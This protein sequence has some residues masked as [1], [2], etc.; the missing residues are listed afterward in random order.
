MNTAAL[1]NIPAFPPVAAKL[2]ELTANDESCVADLVHLLRSDPA[3][4]AQVIRH[5][6]SPLYCVAAQITGLD[7]AVALMGVRKIRTLALAVIGR[8]YFSALAMVDSLRAFWRYSLASALLA[9]RIARRVGVQEDIA[10][11]AALLHDIGR[12]GLMVAHPQQYTRLL[13]TAVADLSAGVE[14]DLLDRERALFDIDRFEAGEWLARTW[15]LP[16]EFR[17]AAGRYDVQAHEHR[18]DLTGV[19]LW[20]GR[21]ANSLGFAVLEYPNRPSYEQILQGLP[22]SLATYLPSRPENLS[23]RIEKE[24]AALDSGAGA[25]EDEAAGT[26]LAPL[27]ADYPQDEQEP[28]QSDYGEGYRAARRSKRRRNL[29]L[30]LTGAAAVLIG[31]LLLL[32]LIASH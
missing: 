28:G 9:E 23:T 27:P 31:A 22:A 32:K 10:Y 2:L 15:N 24:I 13:Q 25:D 16:Q 6:N 11:G 21:I 1:L 20:S 8:T 4:A 26:A 7:H 5:A 14:F 17:E 19:V 30:L 29:W 12:L 3:L 18:F